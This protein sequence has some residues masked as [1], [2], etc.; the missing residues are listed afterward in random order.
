MKMRR[1]TRRERRAVSSTIFER[2]ERRARGRGVTHPARDLQTSEEVPRAR[3]CARF[4]NP[5]DRELIWKSIPTTVATR[6]YDGMHALK[7]ICRCGARQRIGV[8]QRLKGPR[9]WI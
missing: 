9:T 2:V 8:K 1:R 3:Y 5:A 6:V 4:E 7:A